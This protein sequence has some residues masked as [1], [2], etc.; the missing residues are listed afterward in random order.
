MIKAA[1]MY[2]AGAPIAIEQIPEP[3]LGPGEM[4][5]STI[6]SEVCGTDVHLRYSRLS[7][8]PYPIIPGHISTGRVEKTGGT[9]T[10]INGD[11]IV[12]DDVVTFLDVHNTC[13]RCWHCLVA[14]ASTKC[15]QRKVYGVTH[16]VQEGLMGGWAE[17]IHIR[18]DVRTVKLPKE[19][20]PLRLI[21]GGCAL[22]TAL[23]AIER[24]DLKLGES[25][26]IQGAGPVGLCAAILARRSGASKVL[27]IDKSAPRLRIAE[28]FGLTPLQIDYA[29]APTSHIEAVRDA[30]GGRGADVGIEA[31]GVPSAVKEG[32]SMV[33]DAGRYVMVGHYTD[34]GDVAI[35]P[36]LDI[37]RRHMD[38]RGTWGID[39]S[40][41][42]KMVEVLRDAAPV[43]GAQARWEDLIGRIYPLDDVERALDDVERGSVVK[44]V[45]AP[46]MLERA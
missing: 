30:T 5:V 4:L 14:K 8:V 21:A 24:A 33:R 18:A 43:H 3:D 32:L 34:G 29:S 19:V 37:N 1:V 27:I 31:A 20:T 17:K 23:H 41:F 11:P 42:Y 7:G 26:V 38:I 12:A 25:V 9:V 46:N 2:G 15:P 22:P 39:F 35:N 36:H 40:H 10:D 44:A 6:Y 28:R 45:V 16:S 13:N